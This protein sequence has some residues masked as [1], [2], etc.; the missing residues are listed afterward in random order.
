MEKVSKIENNIELKNGYAPL[1]ISYV[2]ERL[3]KDGIL[4]ADDLI[5]TR[6]TIENID[7]E[8]FWDNVRKEDIQNVINN[9]KG[10]REQQLIE[11]EKHKGELFNPQNGEFISDDTSFFDKKISDLEVLMKTVK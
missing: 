9:Y 2:W 5:G 8:K 4:N 11:F 3:A 10:Q 6:E 7:F 1:I